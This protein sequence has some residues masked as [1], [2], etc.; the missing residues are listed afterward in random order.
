M[1]YVIVTIKWCLSKGIS[2]PSHARRRIDGKKVVLHYDFIEPVLTDEDDV[3]VY[4][5]S[6]PEMSSI[7]NS[8]E[9]L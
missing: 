6:S 9:W 3:S 2:V 1:R 4:W 7:L 5:H 8:K